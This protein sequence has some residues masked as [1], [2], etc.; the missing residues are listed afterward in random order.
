MPQQASSYGRRARGF[1]RSVRV[2]AGKVAVYEVVRGIVIIKLL[3]LY[4][5][6]DKVGHVAVLWTRGVVDTGQ[7]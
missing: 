5:C 2:S 7:A 6:E 1:E 3:W 4:C